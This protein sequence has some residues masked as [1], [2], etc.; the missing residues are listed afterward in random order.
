[1]SKQEVDEFH[2]HELM[3]RIFVVQELFNNIVMDHPAGE[4]M[5]K[6]LKKVDNALAAAYQRAGKLRFSK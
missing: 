3:D 6:E 2:R 5:K 4:D 1:M